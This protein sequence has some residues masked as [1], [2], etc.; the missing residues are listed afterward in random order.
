MFLNKLVIPIPT[1]IIN[2]NQPLQKTNPGQK[3]F[4][5]LLTTIQFNVL[6]FSDNEIW[7][8]EHYAMIQSHYINYFVNPVFIKQNTYTSKSWIFS[9]PYELNVKP[10]A[11]VNLAG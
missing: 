11:D 3:Q 2:K 5:I 1:P 9:A 10:F 4:L 8:K 7:T 6:L